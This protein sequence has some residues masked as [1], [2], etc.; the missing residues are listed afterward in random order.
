MPIITAQCEVCACTD[1]RPCYHPYCQG[2]TCWWYKPTL[3]SFCAAFIMGLELLNAD[4]SHLE[5]PPEAA[6]EAAI[7]EPL[8]WLP[9]QLERL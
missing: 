5:D 6:I 2:F 4:A 9:S 1:T 3:C 7:A 8:I